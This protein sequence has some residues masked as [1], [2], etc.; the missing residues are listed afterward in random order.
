MVVDANGAQLAASYSPAGSTALVA[1]HGASDGTRDFFLYEHLHSVLPPIGVGVVTFDR[2]GEGASTG[3]PSRGRFE[4]QV[5]DALAVCAELD[6]RRVGLWGFSQGAWV[7]PMA[8]VASSR[9][10][11]LVL[12]AATGVSPAKQ[13]RYYTS[14]QLRVG[15]YEEDV[16]VRALDLRLRYEGW[17]HGDRADEERL[18]SDLRDAASEPWFEL[19]YL[20]DDLPADEGEIRAWIDEM[21]FDP[22]P[23]IER[24]NVSTL[25]FYGD[26]DTTSPV[27]RSVDAWRSSAANPT[28]CVL[29]GA[30]H[31]LTLSDGT[32]APDYERNLIGWLAA[33]PA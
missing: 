4:V 5:D 19:A 27:Q 23:I 16:R 25:L 11:F 30:G 33:F 10:S 26:G 20:R 2:R 28:I 1:L 14:E 18:R 9:V 17:I 32:L 12:V 3:E 7:A 31:D 24:V 29:R 6:V 15:G 8:A 21:D 22:R 13:M